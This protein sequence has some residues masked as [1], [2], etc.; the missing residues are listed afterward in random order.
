MDRQ[1]LDA[2][3]SMNLILRLVPK[4]FQNLAGVVILVTVLF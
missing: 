2:A 4:M 3:F 1:R